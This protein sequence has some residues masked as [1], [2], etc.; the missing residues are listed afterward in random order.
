MVFYIYCNNCKG[1][2]AL[3]YGLSPKVLSCIQFL[4]LLGNVNVCW[5]AQFTAFFNFV[6]C[7]NWMSTSNFPAHQ[8]CHETWPKPTEDQGTEGNFCLERPLNSGSWCRYWVP[9]SSGH[10]CM[11]MWRAYHTKNAYVLYFQSVTFFGRLPCFKC[12]DS[13]PRLPNAIT[14]LSLPAPPAFILC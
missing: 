8:C 3:C 1:I 11:C 10:Q 4:N 13:T 2:K 7:F 9:F 6:H 14:N 12:I 5:F